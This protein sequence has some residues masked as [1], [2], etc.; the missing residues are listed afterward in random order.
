MAE[1]VPVES[2]EAANSIESAE[3]RGR[4]QWKLTRHCAMSPRS[5]ACHVA[6][7]A[8]VNGIVG[9]G[10]WLLG[11]PGVMVCCAIEVAF[12]VGAVLAYA[13]HAVDGERVRLDGDAL[14]I[15]SV[16]GAEVRVH[17]LNPAWVRLEH[18]RGSAPTLGCGGLRVAVGR[19]VGEPQRRRFVAE[20]SA[21][22]A[23]VRAGGPATAVPGERAG[24]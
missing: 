14:W 20:F 9:G 13:R 12:L 23:A 10:F 7:I 19:H 2:I 5:L 4:R 24:A 1:S 6:A 3:S 8:S 21:A 11:Y 15:E 18:A 16:D 17:V 22:L